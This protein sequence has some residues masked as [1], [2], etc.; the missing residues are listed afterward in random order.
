YHLVNMDAIAHAAGVGKGTLYRYF[1]SKEDLYLALVD[2]AFGL[3]MR[4]LD[5]EGAAGLPPSVALPRMIEAIVETFARHLPYFRLMQRGETRLL[6]R[7]K[8]VIRSRREHIVQL[9]AKVLDCGIEAGA[10]RKVD[11]QPAASML[12]GMVRGGGRE[13]GGNRAERGPRAPGRAAGG[14][15]PRPLPPRSPP[16]SGRFAPMTFV[17]RYRV[18]LV[19]AGLLA[20]IVLLIVLRLREQ[21]ARAVS[22]GPREVVVG[23]A[24][25]EQKDLEVTLSSTGAILPSLQTPICP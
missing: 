18:P 13:G 22:R 3:L 10:F 15:R 7:K 20:V 5:R 24:P 17:R 4:R 8:Q 23:V 14:A 25:P 2:E 6:I 1:P 11:G 21:Q 12:I 16:G 9:V 19:L